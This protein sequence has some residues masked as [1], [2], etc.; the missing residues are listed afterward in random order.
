MIVQEL[1]QIQERCGYLPEG[2]LLGLAQRLEVPLHR[3]H[4]VASFYP[5]YRLTP[6][7]PALVQ[8]CR[9]MACCLHGSAHLR[10]ALQAFGSE[11]GGVVVEGVSCLGQ[12]DRP[13]AVSINDHVYRGLTENELRTRIR[14]AVAHEP[15]PAQH[16]D[17][18][19]LG[20]K[21]DPYQGKP[22][23]EA[24]R[25]W[26]EN[27][28]PDALLKALE[29]ASLRGMG[30]AGF[31]TSRK[32]SAV[33]GAPGDVKYVVCNADESEPGT[34]KDREL[35]RRAPHLVIE[36]MV[37]AGL[38]TGATQG[39]I[40]LRHEYHEE[41]EVLERALAQARELG[42]LG[43]NAAN[44][45]HPFSLELFISPGG[46][47][48]GEETAL[49][50]AME[51][52]RG[53]PRNKPPF[54]VTH[55]LFGKP[56]VIN[57][58]ETLSWV[59]GIVLQ[60]GDWYRNLGTNGATGARFVSISGDVA[61]P[62]VY[63]VPFGQTV[64]ELV[65]E[66]AGGM[67][68]GQRLKAIAPS[69]PSGGFLP[70]QLPVASLPKAFVERMQR[71]QRL[72]AGA[73][74]FSILELPLDF[75][76]FGM[77]GAMLGAAFV[78]YGD[79]ANMVESALNCVQF[80][81]NESCGKCVPCRMGSEKLVGLIQDLLAGQVRRQQ[82]PVVDELA[83]TMYLTSICGLGQVAANPMTSVLKYFPDEVQRCLNPEPATRGTQE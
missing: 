79:R 77:L 37:L 53:E 35:L 48:Q 18:T 17:S 72:A 82:L 6:P 63:E 30:G 24:L 76:T 61:R 44:S 78:V 68:D 13:V 14:A 15:L 11:L 12:C 58:V 33:R 43:A 20:W 5:L 52:R 42:V 46:Y 73:T 54:P 21:I 70:A 9:D 3:L 31:P 74:A 41:G 19:P 51:D 56:T 32:W 69:G 66:T 10:D 71:E 59:P 28:Q 2:E 8:V 23:Y 16:A 57:N 39:W 38:V 62:G 65:F 64:Q 27:P 7:P 36:G 83:Q 22:T 45:G 34:F 1:Q 4:E 67:R 81:R 40:Y 75:A 55:G 80:Y 25:R 26:A 49:L 29:T 50:E 60:G 47:V